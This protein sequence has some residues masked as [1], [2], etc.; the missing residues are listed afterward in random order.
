MATVEDPDLR[1]SRLSFSFWNPRPPSQGSSW[2][3]RPPTS[4]STSPLPQPPMS[5][6]GPQDQFKFIHSRP[7]GSQ[8]R[9]VAGQAFRLPRIEAALLHS[10]FAAPSSLRVI[11][12][13]SIPQPSQ[14]YFAWRSREEE[15]ETSEPP[16]Q[17][18][19]PVISDISVGDS[20]TQRGQLPIK[21]DTERKR[22]QGYLSHSEEGSEKSNFRHYS[23]SNIDF[24]S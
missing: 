7:Q 4:H 3:E 16:V 6:E 18:Q 23:S 22:R 15:P 2:N 17:F 9:R 12:Q 19:E 10:T 14:N 13:P 5:L 1:D 8:S 24:E 21:W 11:P 20:P